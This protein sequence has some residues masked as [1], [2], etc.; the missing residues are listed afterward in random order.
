MTQYQRRENN[1]M[2]PIKVITG[3]KFGVSVE[4]INV[5]DPVALSGA[6]SRQ[7]ADHILK[8]ANSLVRVRVKSAVKPIQY[9]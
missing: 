9:Y 4:I 1:R 2:G 6:K 3:L 8:A 7:E 5:A